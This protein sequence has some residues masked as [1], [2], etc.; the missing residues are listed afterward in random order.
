MKSTKKIK[1]SKSKNG[2]IS[3]GSVSLP[4][5]AFNPKETKFRVSMYLDLDVLDEVRKLAKD[6]G[7]PY[8][9]YINQ[10]LRDVVFGSEMDEKI[11]SIVRQ[12]LSKTGT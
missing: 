7:L 3:Y 10:M 1:K 4:D 12:E 9:T 11:R 2:K 5:D 6:R 8:Q